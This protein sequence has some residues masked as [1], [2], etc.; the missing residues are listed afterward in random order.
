VNVSL[1]YRDG[2]QRDFARQLRNHLTP[3]ETRLW[4]FLRAGKLGVKFRR[5]AAIGAYLADF[6]CFSHRL[7]VELDGPQHLEDEAKDHDARRT[8]WLA[9]QGFRVIRFRNQVLDED[10]WMVVEEIGRA[11]QECDLPESSTPPQPSPSRG[12][13]RKNMGRRLPRQDSEKIDAH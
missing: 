9:S 13:S 2:E 5:Q 7:I 3:A 1:M 8:A 6:V 11:L 12:G 10:I 4:H